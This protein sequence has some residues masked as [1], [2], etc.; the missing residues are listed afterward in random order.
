MP[1]PPSRRRR[2]DCSLCSASLWDGHT[3]TCRR[4]S[5]C[6]E[7]L[8]VVRPHGACRGRKRSRGEHP[9]RPIRSDRD[10]LLADGV[11]R[12][13]AR[14][15]LPAASRDGSAVSGGAGSRQS[16]DLSGSYHRPR[17]PGLRWQTARRVASRERLETNSN[18]SVLCRDLARNG[19]PLMFPGDLG[20]FHGRH[21][22][23]GRSGRW[24]IRTCVLQ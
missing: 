10:R 2:S 21:N 13:P 17:W 1:A 22:R 7:R 14:T 19:E 24:S 6:A 16:R 12:R 20:P 3:P 18:I 23:P 4:R 15:T 5:G 8:H 9:S 11:C